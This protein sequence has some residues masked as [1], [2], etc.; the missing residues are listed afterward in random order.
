ML[1]INLTVC[2]ETGNNPD[3]FPQQTLWF[4]NNVRLLPFFASDG[5]NEYLLKWTVAVVFLGSFKNHCAK[6][7]QLT[8][9]CTCLFADLLPR[10]RVNFC[11]RACKHK[12]KQNAAT[13]LIGYS[14]ALTTQCSANTYTA[15]NRY[16]P[17]VVIY[18]S[19]S[20][21]N[22]FTSLRTSII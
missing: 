4:Y 13:F 10:E 1:K 22:T 2:R 16:P 7:Y 18:M 17:K 20:L 8:A 11:E 6:L 19:K 21:V 9:R 12:E 3:L 5:Q 15:D 14:C